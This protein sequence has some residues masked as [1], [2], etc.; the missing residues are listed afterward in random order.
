M[1]FYFPRIWLYLTEFSPEKYPLAGIVY[2][3]QLATLCKT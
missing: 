1:G 3:T 2:Y